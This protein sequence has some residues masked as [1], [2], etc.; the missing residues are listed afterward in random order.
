[1]GKAYQAE[2]EICEKIEE[3][4]VPVTR[5]KIRKCINKEGSFKEGEKGREVR[6]RTGRV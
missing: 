6:R 5:E 1:M 2:I 3:I 4:R